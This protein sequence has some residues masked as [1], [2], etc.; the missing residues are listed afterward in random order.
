VLDRANTLAALRN[1]A[2]IN[3]KKEQDNI[4][5]TLEARRSSPPKFK[6]GDMVLVRT[7][8]WFPAPYQKLQPRFLGPFAIISVSD[9]V[10]TLNLPITCKWDN[11]I[12][13]SR[14]IPYHTSK[15]NTT[16]TPVIP[17][18]KKDDSVPTVH[19]P[20]QNTLVSIWK[21]NG[22]WPHKILDNNT[23]HDAH[24]FLTRFA[25]DTAN[26]VRN[27]DAWVPITHFINNGHIHNTLHT[28]FKD[29]PR[30][31]PTRQT[32]SKLGIAWILDVIAND[33]GV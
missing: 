3:L 21:I 29:N 7:K 9:N 18:L 4:F 8:E 12:N 11:K 2:Q 28:Y 13:I 26:I 10:L 30:T 22:F 31:M 19:M 23:T 24:E 5:K 27:Q 14:V 1:T 6:T 32:L 20:D 25:D 16:A 15:V 33:T 17:N